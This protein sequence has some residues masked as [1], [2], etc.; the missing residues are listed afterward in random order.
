MRTFLTI[1]VG[2]VLIVVL[3][4]VA[5]FC[6]MAMTNTD[7]ETSS[8]AGWAFGL[9]ISIV[10]VLAVVRS[11][12][13]LRLVPRESIVLLYCMLTIAVPVMNIGL[14][15]PLFLSMRG[16]MLH[17]IKQNNDTYRTVYEA[18]KPRWF[19]VVP[20]V[21]GLAWNKADR[22]LRF[23]RD[24]GVAGKREGARR[25][26]LLALAQE[27]KVAVRD[28]ANAPASDAGAER[29]AK[30]K[31]LVERLGPDE[32][33][34]VREAI[35]N[36]KVLKP[37]GASLGIK[38]ALDRKFESETA[39]SAAAAERLSKALG[40]F[41]EREATYVPSLYQKATWSM[42]QRYDQDRARL[43]DD[44]RRRLDE[45]IAAFTNAMPSLRADVTA[46][47]QTDFAKVRTARAGEYMKDFSGMTEDELARVRTSFVFRG[48]RA[49]RAN[50]YAQKGGE[51]SANQDLASFENSLWSDPLEA[52]SVEKATVTEKTVLTAQK[53]PWGL[54]VAPMAMWGLLVLSIFLFLMCLAEW[55]RRKWV[56]REN[57]AF[58]VVEIVD[59]VIR[60]D[61]A[62]E[63]AED[64]LSPKPR[65]GMFNTVFWI[66]VAIGV[67][68]L[69]IEALGNYKI[70]NDVTV[71]TLNMSEKIFVS[72][73]WKNLDRML[74]V[75]SPI[76]VGILYLVSLEIS[77]SVWV[78]FLAMKLVFFLIKWDRQIIDPCYTG[79]G[80]GRNYPFFSEQLLGAAVCFSLIL[81]FKA[82]RSSRHGPA[83]HQGHRVEEPYLPR[84]MTTAGLIAM[85]VCIGWLLWDLGLTNVPFL[86][87]F[88]V[89]CLM[90]TIAA[91]RA[92]AETGLCTQ[93][94]SYE[95]T[96]LPIIFGMTGFTGPKVFAIFSAVVFLPFT[97]LFRLLPQQL[98]NIELARRNKVR[99]GEVALA[100]ILAF[101][102]AVA[103][104]MVSFL[105]LTYYRGGM[106]YGATS[107]QVVTA[108]GS[109]YYSL[110][111]SHF[112]GENGLDKWTQVHWI[113]IA[114]I[115]VGFGIFGLLS[116]LRSR[117][118]GFPL[119]PVGYLVIL[120]SV[121]TE[122]ASP[123]VKT[124][125][126][127]PLNDY[128]WIWGSA[129][130]A[131][132]VKKL[133]IK[134]GGMR[135]Y[136]HTKPFFIG[137]V[138][139][140]FLFLFVINMVDFAASAKAQTPGV[141]LTPFLKTFHE[142]PPYTP[143]VY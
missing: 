98:E 65:E 51:G 95:F 22:L 69:V 36:D 87:L 127:A 40:A 106:A 48:Q 86:L 3:V 2:L 54:F 113:R 130:V 131:W 9:I 105:I 100:S 8:P 14:V 138:A 24:E 135:M 91:A 64:V 15:R 103:V 108:E 89:V 68:F 120:L 116:L 27:Q 17:F 118:M 59:N 71:V 122:A 60:H 25:D 35:E 33:L 19:P 53:L 63:E 134:Y 31:A 34:A 142:Q 104:G 124:L 32:A 141:K 114:Y 90:L 133:V 7:M 110:W 4:P 73:I 62:L 125:A 72:D 16:V 58:P 111:V 41:D 43:S 18:E 96:K 56:D 38:D 76:L 137:L 77:L 28:G 55:L 61:Y 126:G 12:S 74:F 85:P 52:R 121:L 82:W 67:T 99:Y 79:W 139:G 11:I 20:T 26:L 30:M 119:H 75:L 46:L 29:V 84:R 10:L 92:R 83:G 117:I 81:L 39:L 123:Y 115:A 49:E 128:S 57:L 45:R 21:E 132:S 136:R 107:P 94:S 50:Y 42:R 1:L 88:G 66:G 78:I 93:H 80:G 23:L 143:S 47:S 13:K 5:Q 112:L 129:L 37:L 101:V 109:V 102:V 44:G 140:A 70:T 6:A 97:L